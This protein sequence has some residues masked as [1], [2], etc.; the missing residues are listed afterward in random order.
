MSMPKPGELWMA[1]R[2]VPAINARTK[3]AGRY[4]WIFKGEAV[5]IIG[6]E[7]RRSLNLTNSDLVYQVLFGDKIYEIYSDHF[8]AGYLLL[9]K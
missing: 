7:I 3:G 8:Q 9:I 2:Q 1:F 5:L 6:N 4:E